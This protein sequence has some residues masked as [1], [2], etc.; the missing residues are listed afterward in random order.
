[1]RDRLYR[2]TLVLAVMVLF[3]GATVIPSISGN[4]LNANKILVDNG[5]NLGPSILGN[6][7]RTDN[8][9]NMFNTVNNDGD[10]ETPSL[11]ISEDVTILENGMAHLEI[12]MDISS[13]ISSYSPL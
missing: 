9:E 11:T 12:T 7:I 8:K 2:K 13:R 4:S 6:S 5:F 10:L 1:M 3:V